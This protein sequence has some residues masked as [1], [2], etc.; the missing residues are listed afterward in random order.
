[1]PN[2]ARDT[3]GRF[4]TA[5]RAS[6]CVPGMRRISSITSVCST[7]SRTDRRPRTVDAK[8]SAAGAPPVVV[9]GGDG[10][11][12]GGVGDGGVAFGA[13]PAAGGGAWRTRLKL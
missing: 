12:R 3:P 5:F 9:A 4:W 7:V 13:L 8:R 10:N 11:G 1:M 6:P 2:G